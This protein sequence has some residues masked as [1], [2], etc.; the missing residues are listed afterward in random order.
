MIREKLFSPA[1]RLTLKIV[2][3]LAV[4]ILICRITPV[5]DIVQAV[6]GIRMKPFLTACSLTV[7]C[8]FLKCLKWYALVYDSI[9][10]KRFLPVARS[11]LVGIGFALVTPARTGE[12]MR[13]FWV[14]SDNKVQ[15]LGLVVV[16][17]AMDLIAIIILSSVALYLC[18]PV[19]WSIALACC[20]AAG[21]AVF[22]NAATFAGALITYLGSRTH[23]PLRDKMI[24]L[25]EA[26]QGLSRAKISLVLSLTLFSFVMWVFQGHIL[27]SAFGHVSFKA[28]VVSWPL[29]I[30]TNIIPL[31]IGGVGPREGASLLLLSHTF[32]LSQAAAVSVSLAFFFINGI[33]P[34]TIGMLL[35]FAGRGRGES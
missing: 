15:L 14:D 18:A 34:G 25:F 31:T 23:V 12:L 16:D 6:S 13:V 2:A 21:L 3:S 26:L 7:V 20:V 1:G 28:S 35:S 4:I 17:K 8:I 27:T 10:S 30:L 33:V 22:Y 24:M 19:G 11:F 5:R 29:I 9:R 32:G